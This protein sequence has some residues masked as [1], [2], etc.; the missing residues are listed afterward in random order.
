MGQ[1]SAGF[2]PCVDSALNVAG[3]GK[4]SVLGR[5]HGHGRAFTEGAIE[6]H[7]LA[8]CQGKLVQHAPAPHVGGKIGVGSVQRARDDTVFLALIIFSQIDQRHLRPA[9]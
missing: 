2:F 7:A 9:E 8:G 1:G 4:S 3:G 6:Q 5:L